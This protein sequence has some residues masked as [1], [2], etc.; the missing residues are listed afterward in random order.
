[1]RH[2]VED[3]EPRFALHTLLGLYVVM[4]SVCP[5]ALISECPL[6]TALRGHGAIPK[7]LRLELLSQIGLLCLF[8]K[9]ELNIVGSRP[10]NS[11]NDLFCGHFACI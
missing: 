5:A 6:W 9:M 7:G 8:D 2:P 3:R 1:M 10:Q 4:E 11:W